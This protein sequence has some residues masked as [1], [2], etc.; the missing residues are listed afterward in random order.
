MFCNALNFL[1]QNAGATAILC[2]ATQ[3]LLNQELPN[4]NY[5]ALELLPNSE[6]VPEKLKLEN[7]F[8]R[9]DITVLKSN[10]WGLHDVRELAINQMKE[11]GSCLVIVNTKKMG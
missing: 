3:P 7:K 10:G 2:T 1:T 6:L 4:Q 11:N 9:V 8:R 5:G